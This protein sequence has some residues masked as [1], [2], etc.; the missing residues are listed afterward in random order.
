MQPFGHSLRRALGATALGLALTLAA[1]PAGAQ[2][3]SPAANT[4]EAVKNRG[5]LI[6][7]VNT[8]LAGFAQPDSQGVW[9][10][11]DADYCRAYA[12]AILG[13][14]N[15]VRFVPTTAQA[16]FTALQS[17]EVDVLAR[18]TT[19]TL[20]RDT[21]LGFDFAPT[22]FYDRSEEHTSELQSR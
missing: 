14:P 17:G 15:K 4:L 3:P 7:G 12:A 16:R 20:S 13:D 2:Q 19:W 6:C 21:S 8:G 1:A 9:R 5:T 22:N 11:F 18:N 10:G